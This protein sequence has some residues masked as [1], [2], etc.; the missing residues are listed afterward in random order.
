MTK[1][2]SKPELRRRHPPSGGMRSHILARLNPR[3]PRAALRASAALSP[4]LARPPMRRPGSPGTC[5]TSGGPRRSRRPSRAACRGS[6]WPRPDSD[7]TRARTS[8][9]RAPPRPHVGRTVRVE[10][11]VAHRRDAALL[12]EVLEGVKAPAR[13]VR[14]AVG[15]DVLEVQHEEREHQRACRTASRT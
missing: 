5:R 14:D 12:E 11:L 3:E 9:S 1:R 4:R 2:R 10:R 8:R 15:V 13:T 6:P 7:R